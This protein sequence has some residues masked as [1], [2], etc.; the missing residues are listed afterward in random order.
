MSLGADGGEGGEHG[1]EARRVQEEGGGHVDARD[2]QAGHSRPDDARAVEYHGVEGHR[3]GQVGLAHQIGEKGLAGRDVDGAPHAVD[4][5]EH[6]H[7]PVPDVA[8]ADEQREHEGLHH[9]GGLGHEEDAT[10]AEAVAEGAPDRG[11]EEDGRELERVHEPE[12]ERRSRQ[13]QHEPRLP[14]A[15]H[16]RTD[17]RH[18]LSAPEEPEVPMPERAEPSP[19]CRRCRWIGH[20]GSTLHD[21]A[22]SGP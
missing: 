7:V 15:L 14:H 20:A 13:L 12:L 4:H 11:E 21:L 17:E 1:H 10:L 22:R 3:V 9:H 6:S 2:Q 16:P 19:P 5:G 18:E 8:T